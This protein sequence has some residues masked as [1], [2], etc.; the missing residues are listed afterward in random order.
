MENRNAPLNGDTGL[1][2]FVSETSLQELDYMFGL[3]STY[4]RLNPV[5]PSNL[6]DVEFTSSDFLDLLKVV[7][8]NSNHFNRD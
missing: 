5:S 3:G 2:L 4:S 7:L 6:R 1:S 8:I